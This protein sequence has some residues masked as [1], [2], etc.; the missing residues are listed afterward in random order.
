MKQ[1]DQGDQF[2]MD[3]GLSPEVLDPENR[4]VCESQNMAG[5]I[6]DSHPIPSK[7]EK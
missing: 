7:S 3:Y 6:C 2:C 4:A 5:A 1:K